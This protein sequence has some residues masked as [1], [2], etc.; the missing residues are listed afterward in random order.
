[1]IITDRVESKRA[2]KILLFIKISS[3]TFLFLIIM[4]AIKT[5]NVRLSDFRGF[6]WSSVMLANAYTVFS[7]RKGQFIE[8]REDEIEYKTRSEE[9]TIETKDIKNISIHL[10]VISI[11]SFQNQNYEINIQDFTKYEVRLRIKENFT[12]LQIQS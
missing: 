9:A 11:K 8:W 3:I 1:M 2:E 5:K 12:K 4:M 10:D 6:G 7:K